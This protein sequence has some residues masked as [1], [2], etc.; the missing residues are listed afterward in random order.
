M[1]VNYQT[2]SPASRVQYIDKGSIF[3]EMDRLKNLEGHH[4]RIH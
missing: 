2:V 1:K 3:K 4:Q